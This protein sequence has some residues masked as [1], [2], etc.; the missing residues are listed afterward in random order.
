MLDIKRIVREDQQLQEAI[1]KNNCSFDFFWAII[2]PEEIRGLRYAYKD[3]EQAAAYFKKI[4]WAAV[5]AYEA[6]YQEKQNK[7]RREKRNG[8]KENQ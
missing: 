3:P 4:M 6:G 8:K 7:K 2:R 1:D 5:R